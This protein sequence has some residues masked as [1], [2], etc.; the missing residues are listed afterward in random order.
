[1][2]VDGITHFE[3]DPAVARKEAYE[4]FITQRAHGERTFN[5]WKASWMSCPEKTRARASYD[6]TNSTF[7]SECPEF[8]VEHPDATVAKAQLDKLNERI[9]DVNMLIDSINKEGLESILEYKKLYG[10]QA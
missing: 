4:L 6:F 1:M 7:N 8:Y 10:G 2:S 9:M 5:E 3:V